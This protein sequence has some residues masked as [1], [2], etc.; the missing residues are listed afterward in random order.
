MTQYPFKGRIIKKESIRHFKRK[1]GKE[2]Q[3]FGIQILDED[4]LACAT[5]FD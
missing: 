4:S 2:A 5:F 3:L 1:D